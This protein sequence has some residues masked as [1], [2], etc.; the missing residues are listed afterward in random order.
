MN[1]YDVSDVDLSETISGYSETEFDDMESVRVLK[2]LAV[3]FHTARKIF[4]CCLMAL[5][6]HGGK[7]DFLRWNTAVDEIHAVGTVTNEAQE[8][9]REI[10]TEEES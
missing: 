7:P 5:D 4:L 9:L 2:I 8:R 1:I 10:L 6:A 3:R